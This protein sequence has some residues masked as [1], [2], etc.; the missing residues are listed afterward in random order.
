MT[1]SKKENRSRK[2]LMLSLKVLIH[3]KPRLN[4]KA[5]KIKNVHQYLKP[6]EESGIVERVDKRYRL[7]SEL[8]SIYVHLFKTL[9]RGA[10]KT[11]MLEVLKRVNNQAET[12]SYR[13]ASRH[14]T[15]PKIG[16]SDGTRT[17]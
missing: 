3:A 8:L 10:K 2:L 7:S 1:R 16:G 13:P 4:E 11:A 9:P 5:L 17:R 6:L 14:E 15:E 12:D